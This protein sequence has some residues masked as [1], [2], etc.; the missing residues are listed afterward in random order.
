MADGDEEAVAG[1]LAGLRPIPHVAQAHAGDAERLGG[2][3]HLVDR[4]GPRS[5]RSSAWANSRSCRMR[6]ARSSSR[7]CTSVTLAAKLGEEER[8][9]HRG[10]AA[11]HH[12]HVL[13][14][15][16]EAVAGGAGRDAEAAEL[17]LALQSQPFGLGAGGDDQGLGQPAGAG[18]AGDQEGPRGQVD[19]GDDVVDQ[20]GAD[21]GS[22]WAR[23]CSISHG[24]WITSAKP[25]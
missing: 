2:A 19:G 12:H 18:V 9:L 11:A 6:S 3:Q 23:I 16:E 21:M 13:A 22:A 15:I 7:R 20:F 8:L 14:P 10:V 24:P 17:L 1:E 25:G 4:R 5:P